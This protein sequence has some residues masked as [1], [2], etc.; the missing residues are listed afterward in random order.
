MYRDGRA[1]DEDPVKAVELFQ[2][3]VEQKNAL[4]Q[5]GLGIVD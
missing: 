5:A 1:V 2:K 3:A 4:G